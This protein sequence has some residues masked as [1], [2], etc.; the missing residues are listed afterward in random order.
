MTYANTHQALKSL[1]ASA[2]ELVTIDVNE[3]ELTVTKAEAREIFD[4][5]A[6]GEGFDIISASYANAETVFTWDGEIWTSAP[7]ATAESDAEPAFKE[8]DRNEYSD[9]QA[10]ILAAMALI[11]DLGQDA[12][13][14]GQPELSA[15]LHWAYADVE[16]FR[17]LDRQRAPKPGPRSYYRLGRSTLLHVV[18]LDPDAEV[19]VTLCGRPIYETGIE[20]NGV[21]DAPLCTH[22][23]KKASN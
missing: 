22:C 11:E 23:A 14:H 1:E 15:R 9:R 7:A 2:L 20:A 21:E 16:R 5:L 12:Y 3:G 17:T 19:D 10:Q 6:P 4:E 8:I 13:D 18:D